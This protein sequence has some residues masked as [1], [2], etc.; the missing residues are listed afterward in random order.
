ML[1]EAKFRFLAED[2]KKRSGL[3]L[4]PEKG[5]LVE[6]RLAP[7]AR[8]EGY[9][10]V[11]AL[12]DMMMKGDRRL[13][14]AAAEALATHETFFFRDRT[15]FDTFSNTVAPALKKA[16]GGR[17]ARI[18]CAACSTGQEPYSLAM[19]LEE[20]PGLDADILATDLCASVIEKAKAGLY[21]QFEV[22]RGLAVQRLVKHFEQTGDHFRI[23]PRLR[24]RVR[25]ETGN[26]LEDFARH[27]KQDVIFCRNVLIYF[28]IEAKAKILDRLAAQLQPHGYLVLGA[29]ETV[30]GLTEALRPV[31]GQRGLY[32]RPEALEKIKAA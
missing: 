5:Y 14:V 22:Q 11:D 6:S 1:A 10:S 27:G 24:Q 26:L 31:P 7:L 30:V 9:A 25:F 13:C 28:D 20:T 3:V 23:S 29:A 18:W 19:L 16:L 2:V 21:S 32:A 15:P 4:G 8:S 17:R 12:V